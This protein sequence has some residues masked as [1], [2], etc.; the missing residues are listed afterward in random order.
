MLSPQQRGVSEA[1]AREQA[2][3]AVLS[4]SVGQACHAASVLAQWLGGHT[5]GITQAHRQV[6]AAR[7][8][9]ARLVQHAVAVTDEAPRGGRRTSGGGTWEPFVPCAVSPAQTVPNAL[10]SHR[11]SCTMRLWVSWGRTTLPCLSCEPVGTRPPCVWLCWSRDAQ[12]C[13]WGGR[14][15]RMLPA[16]VG[17][18]HWTRASGSWMWGTL[19]CGRASWRRCC[20]ERPARHPVQMWPPCPACQLGWGAACWPAWGHMA[21]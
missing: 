14:L 9:L 3:L 19:R 12:P 16:L 10:P 6:L 5:R 1:L 15:P 11:R 4:T 18:T 8:A 7:R 20:L 17:G 21:P 13:V 2:A